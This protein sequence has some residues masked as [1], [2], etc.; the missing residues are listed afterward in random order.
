MYSVE[1]CRDASPNKHA[2]DH[3][4]SSCLYHSTAA[5][6][7]VELVPTLHIV[8]P[9]NPCND[10]VP[11]MNEPSVAA[12]ISDHF[13]GVLTTKRI[14]STRPLLGQLEQFEHPTFA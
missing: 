5:T 7:Q 14:G 10:T 13:H 8:I 4:S 3:N 6:A 11:T 12:E 2:N 9:C 1:I